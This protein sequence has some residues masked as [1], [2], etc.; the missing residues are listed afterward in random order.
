MKLRRWLKPLAFI[1]AAL[2]TLFILALAVE[3]YRGKRAWERCRAELEARGEILD[4]AKL[5][6]PPVPDEQNFARTPLLQPLGDYTR[7]QDGHIVWR[8][9]NATE[10]VKALFDWAG[11]GRAKGTW[12]SGDFT[13]LQAIQQALREDT[14]AAT[15]SVREWLKTPPAEPAPDLLALLRLN[16]AELD[17]LH[18]ALQRP[19][20]RFTINYEDSIAALLPHLATLRNLARPFVLRAQARLAT[21][22]A[23]GA[24]ADIEDALALADTV[25]SEPLL[26]SGLVRLAMVE[27]ALQPVWEGLARRQ[28]NAEQLAGLQARLAQVN[29][30]ADM[31]AA[32]RGE[33]AFCLA[34]MDYL[35]RNPDSG[36]MD[37]G[38]SGVPP[39]FRYWLSG[40]VSQNRVAIV[41]MFDASLLPAYD[42]TN[43]VVNLATART[44][45]QEAETELKT[46]SPYKIFARMLLPAL[47]RVMER[48]ARTQAAVELALTGCALERC[49]LMRGAYPEQLEQLVPE[50]L[51]RVPLDP[52]TR[53]PL[54][55]RRTED[56]SFV[57]WSVGANLKDDDA[58]PE[59]PRQSSTPDTSIEGDW[60][61][62]Y[63]KP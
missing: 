49:R 11:R 29:V 58:T 51:A 33:R 50:F 14:N 56:G 37:G 43:R 30:V 31:S 23:A 24:L 25:R 17:E 52:A 4:W 8:D 6:P 39:A 57:L 32:M 7:G 40:W 3:N 13:D 54:R 45:W 10:R 60:V 62:R 20:S 12:R 55:Y 5:V 21:G 22:D 34:A 47:N 48:T 35:R 63:P 15:G 28:W 61:W 41:R 19:A 16:Q 27:V 42:P 44:Q 59:P 46:L 36:M 18:A 38:A 1:F 9:T 26:I 2:I 53:E